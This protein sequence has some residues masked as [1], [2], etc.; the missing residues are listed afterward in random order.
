MYKYVYKEHEHLY[1]N[2]RVSN[3]A[4]YFSH[5]LGIS[6]SLCHASEEHN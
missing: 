1:A 2:F 4:R 5:M 6:V 3:S